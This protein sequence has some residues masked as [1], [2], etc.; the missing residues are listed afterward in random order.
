[1]TMARGEFSKDMARVMGENRH[2]S[3]VMICHGLE[4]MRQ[5]ALHSLLKPSFSL[6]DMCG[7][8]PGDFLEAEIMLPVYI[9]INKIFVS[10]VVSQGAKWATYYPEVFKAEIGI[11]IEYSQSARGKGN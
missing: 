2:S 11:V 8:I 9:P 3:R 10:L 7:V 5:L 4:P 1:M 6:M